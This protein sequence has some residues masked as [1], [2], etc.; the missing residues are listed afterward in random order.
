[1]KCHSITASCAEP[2]FL[3]QPDP[4]LLDIILVHATQYSTEGYPC[5]PAFYSE[6]EVMST[7]PGTHCYSL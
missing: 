4:D 6:F 1:M 3:D 2:T 5:D 7:F